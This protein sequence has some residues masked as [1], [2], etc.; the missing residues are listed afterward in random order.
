M[1]KLF[2][3]AGVSTL[4]GFV[5]YRV[6]NSLKREAILRKS[7]HTDIKLIE[8]PNPMTKEDAFAFIASHADFQAVKPSAKGGISPKAKTEKT[9]TK[10][11]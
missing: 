11:A 9:A 2:S 7:G 4:N 8:L 6:A 10:A 5:K 3:V 1:D